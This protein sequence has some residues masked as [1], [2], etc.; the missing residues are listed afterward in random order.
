MSTST[1]PI[2][3]RRRGVEAFHRRVANQK[4]DAGAY[5]MPSP[6]DI[7]RQ[8]EEIPAGWSPVE[9][10]WRYLN[11]RS[12]DGVRGFDGEDYSFPTFDQSQLCVDFSIG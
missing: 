1:Q 6:E 3:K 8:C 10:R 11:A 9:R 2:R 12:V 5:Y 4:A 7:Q